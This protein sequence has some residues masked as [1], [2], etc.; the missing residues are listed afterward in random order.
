MT[1]NDRIDD[2]SFCY[3]PEF[4]P[5]VAEGQPL[6]NAR[7]KRVQRGE[8]LRRAARSCAEIAAAIGRRRSS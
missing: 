1:L 7:R 2:Q 4:P 6:S 5:D 8:P 3:D